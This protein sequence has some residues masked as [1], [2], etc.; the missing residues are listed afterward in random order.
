MPNF[1]DLSGQRFGKWLV[2]KRASNR[3]AATMFLCLCKCG[4]EKLV[5]STHL[6]SGKTN[7]CGC[8]WTTH[9]KSNSPIYRVWDSMVRR[10]HN[11]NHHAY[12]DY[13]GRGISVCNEWRSFENFY[14]DMGDA[15]KDMTLERI[16]NSLGYFK[17]NVKW[18]SRVEQARN[19]RVTK[20]SESTVKEIKR[21]IDS[22]VTQMQIAAQFGCSRSNIGHIA[23]GSTWRI[24]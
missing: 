16:D 14:A 13:G 12:K 6:V 11:Q 2:I 21:L 22:G 8:S 17:E 15:P 9:G 23:Q 3:N 5:K 19:R 10:C 4:T 20:L 24:A 7:S 18:A 1:K